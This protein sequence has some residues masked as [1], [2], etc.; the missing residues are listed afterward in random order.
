MIRVR[1]TVDVITNALQQGAKYDHLEVIQG[2]PANS[3]LVDVDWDEGL[4]IISY[5]FDIN[6]GDDAIYEHALVVTLNDTGRQ[7]PLF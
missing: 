6:D 5:I 7:T 4:N 2:L 1:M 3:T